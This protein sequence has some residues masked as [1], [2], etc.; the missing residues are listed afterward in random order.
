MAF[1]GITMAAVVLQLRNTI[2]GG[3]ISKIAQPESD[4]ILMT[5]HGNDG[6]CRVLISADASLPLVYI[7]ENNKQGP[8]TAP[9]FCMLLRKHIQGGR[10]IS[11]S[12]PGLERILEIEVE[13][14]DEMGDICHKKLIFE[15]MGKHSNIIFTNEE[16]IIIDSIKRVS[17]AVSSVREV[18]PGRQYFIPPTQDKNELLD[19]SNINMAELAKIG[20]PIFKAIYGTFTGISPV[21]AHEIC[22]R[23]G[24]DSDKPIEMLTEEEIGRLNAALLQL[25]SEILAGEFRPCI[26]YEGKK[27]KEYAAIHLGIYEHEGAQVK[28][29]ASISELLEQF[30]REKNTVVRIRQKSVELRHVVATALER[31]IKKYDLQLK[32]LKDTE[33][34][35]TY[36]IY[37]ELLNTYGYSVA[38]GAE[39]AVVDN[40]YTGEKLTIPLDP[41][42]SATE[43]AQRYFDKYGKQKR[44][45]EALT[46]LTEEVGAEI[47]HLR[48]IQTSL[49]IALAEE[50]LLEIKQEL[51]QSGYI[52]KKNNGNKKEKVTSKP[53]H[54]I[55]SDGYDI[56]VGKNNFQNDELTFKFANGGDWWFHAK[57]IP[58]SHVI[59]RSKQGEE[60]PDRAYEEAAKLAAYYSQGRDQE[61]VEVDYVRRKEVKKPGG[62]KPGF[63]VYYT[64]YSMATDSDISM[65]TEVK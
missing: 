36:R 29:V 59:L 44:T 53:F 12:Q 61:K 48:S 64:N 2:L 11:V 37:G 17:S 3:R 33:D 16:G 21:V 26:A 13:H 1:D 55:S 4:E 40:Y 9:T 63:V 23:S 58:G 6:N 31:N 56:Y 47:E 18:L 54:Y 35:D 52:R 10:I 24:I 32:Q 19:M 41:Q 50:D 7:T 60:I 43:N 8:L 39:Q 30:Y 65:L 45:Y 5:V 34:R 27:P 14:L 62:A 28:N 49:D 25:R 46:G 15:L 20:Q 42:L 38:G 22:E 57:K 51:V